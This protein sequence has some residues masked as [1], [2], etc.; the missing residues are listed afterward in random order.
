MARLTP[1]L[2]EAL[3]QRAATAARLHAMM[4]GNQPGQQMLAPPQQGPAM[5]PMAMQQAPLAQPPAGAPQIARAPI[6]TGPPV[7]P[8]AAPLSAAAGSRPKAP[9]LNMSEDEMPPIPSRGKRG[10]KR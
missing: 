9:Q 8:R 1:Q 5:Q 3:R 6:P 2:I 10:K 4:S 7:P